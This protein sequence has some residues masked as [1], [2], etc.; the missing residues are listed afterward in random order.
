M[1]TGSLGLGYATPYS[2]VSNSILGIL[3]AG[4]ANIGIAVRGSSGQT[5]DLQ[6]WQ[7]SGGTVVANMQAGG[8]LKA[9]NVA[10]LNSLAQLAQA[11]SGGV[12]IMGRQ[13]AQYSSPGANS[14]ALY[15]RDGTNAGTLKLVVRAG[16]AGAETTILDNIPT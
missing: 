14:A 2:G 7:N 5:A 9:T 4:A 10:T 13:T 12:M 1:S 11:N 6:V 15:F 3:T 8:N 16:A